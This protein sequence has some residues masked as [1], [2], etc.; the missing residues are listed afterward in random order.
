[1]GQKCI[2]CFIGCE[3]EAIY[4]VGQNEEQATHSCVEHVQELKADGD[5]VYRLE[6]G[7]GVGEALAL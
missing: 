1:M 3:R 5:K 2:C 7:L 6:N 4:W